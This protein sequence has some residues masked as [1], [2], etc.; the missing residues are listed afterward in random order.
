MPVNGVTNRDDLETLIK[1][2]NRRLPR[3][4]KVYIG[5]TDLAVPNYSEVA[6]YHMLPEYVPSSYF[7]ESVPGR[8]SAAHLAADISRADALF[9]SKVPESDRRKIWPYWV[10]GSEAAN[11]VV[12]SQFCLAKQAGHTLLFFKCDG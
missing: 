3:G 7:L 11:E 12:A 6:L 5:A 9:L 10:R 4:S 8:D 1:E 2:A